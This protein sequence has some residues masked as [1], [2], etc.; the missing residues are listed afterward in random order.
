MVSPTARAN[1]R[2]PPIFSYYFLN[3]FIIS[4]QSSETDK[5]SKLDINASES[6]AGNG[7]FGNIGR[8]C[9]IKKMNKIIFL[10]EYNNI[11]YS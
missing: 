7:L 3:Y 2:S 10:K 4:N 8:Y 6:N 11:F 5:S 9:H 1:V